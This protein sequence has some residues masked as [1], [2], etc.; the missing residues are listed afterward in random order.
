M[1]ERNHISETP[2]GKG[3]PAVSP[4]SATK[5]VERSLNDLNDLIQQ[6]RLELSALRKSNRRR[7][8]ELNVLNVFIFRLDS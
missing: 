7:L 6:R 2:Y 1:T 5:L 3:N 4:V 8:N